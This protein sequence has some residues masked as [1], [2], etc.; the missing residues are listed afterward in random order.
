VARK[1]RRLLKLDVGTAEWND[2]DRVRV[3]DRLVPRRLDVTFPGVQGQPGL[4]FV[5]EVRRGVPRCAR[6]TITATEDG[7]EVRSVDVRAVR[8]EEWI[9]HIV[10][11][12]SD[13]IVSEENGTV[14][15]VSRVGP[16]EERAARRAIREARR[17]GRR[18]VDDDLYRRVA[19]IHRANEKDRPYEAVEAAF[20]CSYRTAARYVQM[21]REKGFLEPKGTGRG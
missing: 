20:Q 7:R 4:D 2:L 3:G 13:P 19:E 12:A 6:L 17:A 15:T 5:I 8:L 18:R 11:L 10:A 16:E 14:A 21:A 9:E 1:L